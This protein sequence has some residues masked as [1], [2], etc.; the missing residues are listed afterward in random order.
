MLRSVYRLLMFVVKLILRCLG[1]ILGELVFVYVLCVV[2][3]VNCEDGLRCFVL[4]CGRI[5]FGWMI[6]LVVNVM[7]SLN[8]FI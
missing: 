7:G 3:S 1:V 5:F 8:C 6:V 2:I 4:W